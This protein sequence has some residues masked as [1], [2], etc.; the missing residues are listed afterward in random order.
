MENLRTPIAFGYNLRTAG[1]TLLELLVVLVILGLLA[2]VATPQVLDYLDRARTQSASIQ[3]NNLST[4][5]DLYRLDVGR[6]PSAQEGLDSLVT[7]PAGVTTWFGPYVKKQ[8]M[9]IDPW[10]HPYNYRIPGKNGAYDI[11][12]LGADNAVGGEGENQ[13]LTN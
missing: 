10:G 9:L 3:I 6:Y 11:Y 8:E 13:D 2:A 4:A 1:F 5:L 12:T 7:A